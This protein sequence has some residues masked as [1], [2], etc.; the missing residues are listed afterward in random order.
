MAENMLKFI[1]EVIYSLKRDYG[2][3]IDIYQNVD[4]V[5]DR[6]TGQQTMSKNKWHVNRAIRLPRGIHRDAIFTS[7]GK[8]AFAY[9][10]EIQLADRQ[11]IVDLKDLPPGFKMGDE[12]WY[13][14]M[15]KQRFEVKSVE[16]YDNNAALYIILK[17]LTAAPL[18]QIVEIRMRHKSG[19]TTI[20]EG[21]L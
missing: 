12:N 5:V 14:I 4:I 21:T 6:A 2:G 20:Q 8:T 15:D 17:Q 7:T 9:G 3:P 10:N 13:V 16:E 19:V 18:E 11:I 1:K